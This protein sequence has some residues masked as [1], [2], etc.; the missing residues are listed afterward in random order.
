M[1]WVSDVMEK[2][3]VLVRYSQVLIMDRR[4]KQ[5][6]VEDL[7]DIDFTDDVNKTYPLGKDPVWKSIVEKFNRLGYDLDVPENVTR[8]PTTVDVANEWYWKF[9]RWDEE[10]AEQ[11]EAVNAD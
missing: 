1:L 6:Q 10:H 5:T 9:Q 8:I 11:T 2:K 3:A 7:F 4:D